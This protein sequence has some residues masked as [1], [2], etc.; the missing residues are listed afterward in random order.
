MESKQSSSEFKSH[1]LKR[2]GL[3]K[4]FDF[5]YVRV[6]D[7][8]S[9]T[10]V[11]QALREHKQACHAVVF[12]K[13]EEK[14]TKFI[15][16]PVNGMI[17]TLWLLENLSDCGHNANYGGAGSFDTRTPGLIS[18]TGKHEFLV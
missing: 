6:W 4:Q 7:G 9:D 15:I 17:N 10:E 16:H 3:D 13:Q 2:D 18:R 12:C 5:I 8:P 14:A 1:I 11:K